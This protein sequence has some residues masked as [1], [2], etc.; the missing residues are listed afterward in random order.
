MDCVAAIDEATF[1]G[2]SAFVGALFDLEG[3]VMKR[4]FRSVLVCLL[5]IVMT[6]GSAPLKGFVGIELPD[7]LNFSK[8]FEFEA[9]ASVYSGACGENLTWTLDESTGEL[10]ISGTGA[11]YDFSYNNRPWVAD[12][13]QSIVVGNGVTSIG[14][15]AFYDCD[16][17][18]TVVIPDCLLRIGDCS[19]AF[20]DNITSINIPSSVTSIGNA[21]YSGCK[22]LS[23]ITVD[24]ENAYFLSDDNILYDKNKTELILYPATKTNTHYTINDGIESIGYGAFAYCYNLTSVTIPDSVTSLGWAAFGGSALTK[25]TG[26]NGIVRIG[27]YS[28]AECYGLTSI[29]I[30][31]N[32]TWIGEY[33]FSDCYRLANVTMSSK[34]ERI[35]KRA[36]FDCDDLIAVRYEGTPDDWNKV[37]VDKH[38]DELVYNI[39]FECNSNNPYFGKG[40]CGENIT[41]IINIDGELVL[42]G[43]GEVP[44]YNAVIVPP[45]FDLRFH[46]E[47]VLL[48]EGISSIGDCAFVSCEELLEVVVPDS[49]IIIG[50]YT[51]AGCWD[52]KNI[53]LGNNVTI[54]GDCAFMECYDLSTITIMSNSIEIGKDA[55]YERTYV[56]CN[57]GSSA[58]TYAKQ[59]NLKYFLLDGDIVK[60]PTQTTISYGDSIIL[61]A[62]M[63]EALPSGWTVKWTADNGNF[64]YLANGETCIITPS[65]SGDTT[66]TVTVYDEN[67][68]EISKDTQT[69]KSKAGFF[70]KFAAFFRKLFGMTKIIQQSISF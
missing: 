58:H 4:I 24:S 21:A 11:M 36:F 33:A 56:C 41:W 19:F 31:D 34:I 16:N 45:W 38:N 23:K 37:S 17:I 67:G 3:F 46:I 59:N 10:V 12:E 13:I 61:H 20:C 25:I 49:V 66:F 5:A 64:S 43:T 1:F 65:K 44:S 53:T 51:F 6:V 27:E 68:N 8:L 35:D 42:S 63:N 60:K 50:E 52:L 18:K 26:G 57:T 48:S 29:T 7:W 28:F 40:E 70:D 30:P 9:S 54:V 22:R 14:N 32:V 39:L 15:N 2:A 69:M 62:D 55:L 47:R